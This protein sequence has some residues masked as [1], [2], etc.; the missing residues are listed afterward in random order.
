[1]RTI[2]DTIAA[3]NTNCR[4]HGHFIH[5]NRTDKTSFETVSATD[6]GISIEQNTATFAFFKG[7]SRTNIGTGWIF[8][9]TTDNNGKPSLH[10]PDR[11]DSNT[12]VCQPRF[13]LPSGTGKHAALT[14]NTFFRFYNCK[15]HFKS[16][17][18]NNIPFKH[19]L[20]DLIP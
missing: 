14:A 8:T 7:I 18:L 15:F 12:G 3:M 10:S 20:W 9:G 4:F 6:A 11:A 1:M 13:S 5:F 16:L 2:L 19:I 17:T